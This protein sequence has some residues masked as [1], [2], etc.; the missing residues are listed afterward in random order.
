MIFQNPSVHRGRHA[1]VLTLLAVCLLNNC[2]STAAQPTLTSVRLT[3]N[4]SMAVQWQGGQGPFILQS[5]SDLVTW[6]DLQDPTSR[7]EAEVV[8]ANRRQFLRL[9]DLDADGL[10]GAFFGLLQTE[11]GEF[12]DLLGRHRLKSRM[13]LHRSR[14]LVHVTEGATP[15]LYWRKLRLHFQTHDGQHVSTWSGPLETLGRVT[16]P[17]D[18]RMVIAWTNGV[19]ESRR[20]YQLAIE[21][22]YPLN[23]V[24]SAPYLASDPTYSLQC[25]YAAPQ[26]EFDGGSLAFTTT[27][28]DKINLVEMAPDSA[29]LDWGKRDYRVTRRGAYVELRYQEG[30]PLS[31]GSP[32]WIFKTLLLDRWLAPAVMGGTLPAFSTDSYFARTLFPGHHN[33]VEIVLI[34]PGLDPALPEETRD[35]LRQWNIRFLYTFKDLAGV[36]AG[37][38]GEDLRLIGFDG[39]IRQP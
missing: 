25:V 33:F 8:P 22:P 2:P 11:Q 20:S 34:E 18:R 21:F 24:R 30:L 4:G 38:D 32:P 6:S 15:S 23:T 27:T 9:T 28:L 19:A 10:Q 1:I 39:S 14:D 7:H 26:P 3:T 35:L 12:G 13:W 5:S 37:G 31:Q 36:T 16:T 29:G 17:T